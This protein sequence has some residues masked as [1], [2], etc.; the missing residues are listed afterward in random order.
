MLWVRDVQ[1]SETAWLAPI[2]KDLKLIE[3]WGTGIR[4]M[5]AEAA[6][7][8]NIGLVLKE[9]GNTFQVQFVKEN[10]TPEVTPEVRLLQVM[11]GEMSR[12]EIR[13][14]LK[15]KDEEH[16]RKAYLLP[17]LQAEL[18]E[19]TIPDKPRSSK[20]RYRIT[21]KGRTALSKTGES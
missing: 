12:K 15:L 21:E 14:S 7:Y 11:A 16:F 2:F 4:K 20:Q 9:T 18:I 6:K 19:M 3:A 10:R 5:Q 8:R 1:K 17:A 13:E